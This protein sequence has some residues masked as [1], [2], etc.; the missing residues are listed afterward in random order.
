MEGSSAV[1][2]HLDLEINAGH[3]GYSFKLACLHAYTHIWSSLQPN[4]YNKPVR[5]VLVK[6]GY[7]ELRSSTLISPSFLQK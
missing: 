2:H 7:F 3:G 5:L 1:V 4:M 6:C